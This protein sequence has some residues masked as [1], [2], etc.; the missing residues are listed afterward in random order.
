MTF[1]KTVLA[2]F[3]LVALPL[4]AQA[5]HD[6][7]TMLPQAGST[8]DARPSDMGSI[9]GTVRTIDDHAVSDA[10]IEI[11]SLRTGQ[12]VASGF[13]TQSGNFEVSNLP[14]GS[15]DVIA[16]S[17]LLEARES[18]QVQGPVIVALQIA[19]RTRAVDGSTSV[20]VASL[21]V[22]EKA[23]QEYDKAQTAMQ[24]GKHEEALAHANK[25]LELYPDFAEALTVRGVLNLD[26][27]DIAAATRDLERAIQID[28]NYGLAYLA[29]GAAY[30]ADSRY[31]DA[32][33]T[34]EHG[35][36]LDP[37]GWQGYF[38]MAKAL[39]AKGDYEMSLQQ[40]NRAAENTPGDYPPL[41][42]LR[43]HDY[44]GLKKYADAKTELET[45]LSQAPQAP[46]VA[47]V[48]HTL[49]QLQSVAANLQQ[50]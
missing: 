34:V 49:E 46:G 31:D 50:Q 42:L 47:D 20:S 11:R 22:P 16:T 29:L 44:I 27:H 8:V 39:F 14:A 36:T 24:K 41:H 9:S 26:N 21:K 17:G 25:A 15:Y 28:G 37:K 5:P 48:R 40:V 12:V 7:N 23:R 19:K 43:A 33:R 45:Y 1:G 13:S 10:R 35:V 32:L 18:V 38:E 2:A 3:L 6:F 30:N 4:F